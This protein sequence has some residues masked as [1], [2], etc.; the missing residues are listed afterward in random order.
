[1]S[2]GEY[3]WII[4]SIIKTYEETIRVYQLHILL[5]KSKLNEHYNYEVNRIEEII[6]SE[7]YLIDFYFSLN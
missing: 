5:L 2:F 1:M 7:E 6:E 4:D 3:D